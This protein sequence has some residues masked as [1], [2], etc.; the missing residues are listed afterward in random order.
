VTSYRK[1]MRQR[2]LINHENQL[3]LIEDDTHWSLIEGQQVAPKNLVSLM[4][5]I[6]N[7]KTSAAALRSAH[8]DTHEA[9]SETE[10]FQGGKFDEKEGANRNNILTRDIIALLGVTQNELKLLESKSQT[11]NKQATQALANLYEMAE[12]V[13]RGPAHTKL[14][15]RDELLIKSAGQGL[16][17]AGPGD[18]RS[19]RNSVV[20]NPKILKFMD[21]MVKKSTMPGDA[22]ENQMQAIGDPDQKLGNWLSQAPL[23]VT[24]TKSHDGEDVVAVLREGK[25][26]QITKNG[27]KTYSYR[28][29]ALDAVSEQ[30]NRKEGILGAL[31]SN[32]KKF[33]HGKNKSRSSDDFYKEMMHAELDNEFGEKKALTR[34][35]GRMGNKRAGQHQ[36]A[37]SYH[38]TQR[39][40]ENTRTT[41]KNPAVSRG[42]LSRWGQACLPLGNPNQSNSAQIR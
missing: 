7:G 41:R 27:K 4:S 9:A 32:S 22:W 18:I 25:T 20:L 11:N 8:Q 34:H 5:S 31:L 19:N 16:S 12:V 30:K 37:S 13:H 14:Q 2:G 42:H 21:L 33:E 24:K 38:P 29:L 36:V 15:I 17:P 40:V 10:R 23:F 3:R 39:E 6:V 26:S 35:M 1:L 28:S